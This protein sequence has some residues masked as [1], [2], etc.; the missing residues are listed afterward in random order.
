[1][2]DV[3]QTVLKVD[4]HHNRGRSAHASLCIGA[5][6]KN[7]QHSA[8]VSRLL[9]HCSAEWQHLQKQLAVSRLT[10]GHLTPAVL[11]Q[12]GLDAIVMPVLLLCQCA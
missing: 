4:L 9:E 3:N 1:M 5:A 7:V 2:A 8:A 10:S 6:Q 11:L 12:R